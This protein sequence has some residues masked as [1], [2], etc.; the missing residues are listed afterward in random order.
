[1]LTAYVPFNNPERN[2]TLTELISISRVSFDG[3]NY[4][5]PDCARCGNVEMAKTL[6]QLS[7]LMEDHPCVIYTL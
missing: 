3:K 4:F 2:A 6:Q 1:M 5:S 7:L